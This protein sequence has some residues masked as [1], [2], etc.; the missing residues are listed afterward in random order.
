VVAELEVGLDATLESRRPLLLEPTPLAAG[1]GAL[2][3]GER[4]A[5]PERERPTERLRRFRRRLGARFFD[6]LVEALGVQPLR[7]TS[8]R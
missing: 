4:R 7:I 6:E 3:I 1:D 8:T 2:E 5:A